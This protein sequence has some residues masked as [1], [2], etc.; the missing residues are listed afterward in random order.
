MTTVSEEHQALVVD[1]AVPVEHASGSARV[2][3]RRVI[4]ASI[5][6]YYPTASQGCDLLE[7]DFD[8]H[9]VVDDALYLIE[10]EAGDWRGFLSLAT[11][12]FIGGS[13]GGSE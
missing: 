11:T 7:V 8:V 13:F 4:R 5:G 2:T 12:L 9:A 10:G 1:A 3:G 6:C